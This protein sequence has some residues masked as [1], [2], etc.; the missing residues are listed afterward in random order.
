MTLSG[1]DVV[2]GTSAGGAN[3]SASMLLPRFLSLMASVP[4]TGVFEDYQ[5]QAI[6]Y[7]VLGRDTFEGR[8]R[9]FRALREMYL[10]DPHRFLFR[11]LR[12]LWDEDPLAR[13][14][15]A[16]LSVLARDSV[17]RST[18]DLVLA[19]K[20]GE[21]ISNGMLAD[22][23]LTAFPAYSRATAEKIGRNTAASWG[24]TG[25]LVGR[26]VKLRATVDASPV[27]MAY[28]LFI[29]YLEGLR[30]R[31]LLDS[32]W[33]DFLDVPSGEREAL[34]MDAARRGYV[35]YKSAGHVVEVGF[36]HLLRPMKEQT[37]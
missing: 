27:A 2:E 22:A 33:V 5:R 17:F 11:S 4:A 6:D 1:G 15:L 16:G 24:Q 18:A 28:A 8:R 36:R 9:T 32:R 12:D 34:A 35:E 21:R 20:P 26:Q 19:A 10:L 14:S 25:H 29:G 31:P 23:V 3:I 37:S 30:G 7:N 13:P